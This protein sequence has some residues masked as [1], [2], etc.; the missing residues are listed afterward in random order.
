LYSVDS[1]ANDETPKES[2]PTPRLLVDS[3]KRLRVLVADDQLLVR[4]GICEL[5]KALPN[6]EI[7]GEA[8]DGCEALQLIKM[9][10]P[11]IVL[12]DLAMPGMNGLEALVLAHKQFPRVKVIIL[13]EHASEKFVSRALRA[14][15]AGFVVKDDPVDELHTAIKSVAGGAQYL[16]RRLTRRGVFGHLEVQPVVEEPA[17]RLTPRQREVLR[18]IAEGKSTKEI[19]TQLLISVN[20]VKTHRLKL[21]EKL[22][23]HE[24]SGVVRYAAKLGLIKNQ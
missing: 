14:G 15:A 12:M 8:R 23:V 10:D 6:L 17:K 24:I 20:T 13:S 7:I 11:D 21:M 22:G 5:V 9:H 4:A 16:S 18:Q 19:A 2:Y 1:E 3:S